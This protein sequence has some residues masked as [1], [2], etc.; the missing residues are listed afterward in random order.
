VVGLKRGTV[1]HCRSIDGVVNHTALAQVMSRLPNAR[2]E[3]ATD[4]VGFVRYVKSEEEIAFVRCSAE[5]ASAGAGALIESARPGIDA[6]VLYAG[7]TA[8]LSE[9]RSEYYPLTLTLDPIGTLKPRRYTNPPLGKRLEENAMINADINAILGAQLTQVTQPVLLGRLPTEWQRVIELQKEVYEEGLTRMKPGAPF[10]A[11]IDFVNGYGD[12]RNMKTVMQLHGCGY[13]DD[14]PVVDVK[15]SGDHLRDLRIETGNA[16]VW[17]PL[18][19]TADKRIRFSW[20]GPVLVTDKGGEGLFTRDH[21][22]VTIP[23]TG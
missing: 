12:R 7:V 4:I 22:I 23:A 13:G 3:D 14:G 18:A 20:G 11:L 8:R 5:A 1:T 19:M 2:F 6:A 16:F 10:G 9:L 15:F 21:G 17:K